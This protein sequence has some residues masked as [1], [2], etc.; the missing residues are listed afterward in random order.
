MGGGIS[1]LF[2]AY[3]IYKLKPEFL[4]HKNIQIEIIEKSKRAGGL[5]ETQTS[6][7]GL[8]EK[9]ANGLISTDRVKAMEL[10]LGL[11][12]MAMN[13]ENKKRFIFRNQKPRQIPL[14]PWET[15][16][17]LT[18][19]FKKSEPNGGETLDLYARRELGAEATK[20]L[21]EPVV[22]GIFGAPANQL[23]AKLVYEYFFKLK[24]DQKEIQKKGTL[25]PKKGM[26][27]L[28]EALRN[29][30][31]NKGAQFRFNSHI[32]SE[33]ELSGYQ[34][35]GVTV[36][37]TNALE[38]ARLT[39]KLAPE[40]SAGLSKVKYQSLWSVTL[41][42]S[43]VEKPI[44]G[45]GCLFPRAEGF[46]AYGVLF[47]NFIFDG[48]GPY[49]TETWIL[50]SLKE[51]EPH[52]GVLDLILKDRRRLY[53]GKTSAPD[54]SLFTHWPEA[55]PLYDLELENF[56]NQFSPK[57]GYA[58][59]RLFVTGNYWGRIGLSKIL[60]QSFDVAK[61]VLA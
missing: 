35:S 36:L 45:F 55:L 21:V 54:Q 2:L 25:A 17:L 7:W 26:G 60:D 30:L 32:L 16:K 27:A 5:I 51:N 28:I 31:E 12:L 44:K 11:Q 8:I 19:Y 37:A 40:L 14:G 52:E 6:N 20:Y 9:A 50:P 34:E 42:F 43:Q 24:S 18:N 61:G 57:R 58:S 10:D 1:G 22:L 49:H 56:L 3:A 29:H 23:S 4:T 59:G 38:A 41:G 46:S 53:G 33:G 48:R 47:N 13:P 39:S 15:I